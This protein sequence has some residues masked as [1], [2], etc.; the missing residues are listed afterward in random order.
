MT[1][2]NYTI[3]WFVADAFLAEITTYNTKRAAY[4]F[5]ANNAVHKAM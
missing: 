4:L 3:E 2:V 5:T 1:N